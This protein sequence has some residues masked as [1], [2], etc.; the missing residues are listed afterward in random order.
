[1][2]PDNLMM[3]ANNKLNIRKS[4]GKFNSPD[5]IKEKI[6]SYQ[7]QLESMKKKFGN[8]NVGRNDGGKNNHSA[9]K[10]DLYGVKYI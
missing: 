1:M 2:K 7:A 4:C 8:N 9:G 3:Y 5:V 6:I 10:K